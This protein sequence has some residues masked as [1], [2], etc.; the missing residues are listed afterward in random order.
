[1]K[2]EGNN[3]PTER[4]NVNILYLTTKC[5]L[6]CTYCYEDLSNKVKK[7]TSLKDLI[8][9]VDDVL[10][11]EPVD[12]QTLFVLFGGEPTLEWDNIKSIVEYTLS[13]KSNVFFNIETNG[14]KFQDDLFLEN[15][16]D[17][18]HNKP[19]SV[20]ISFDGI[21]NHQRVDHNDNDS[22]FR[23]ISVLNKFKSLDINW[24]IRYTIT[25]SNYTEFA[26]DIAKIIKEFKPKRV[27]TSED[28]ASFSSDDYV[29]IN[30]QKQGLKYLWDTNRINTPI[31]NIFCDT[32]DGCHSS[33][34]DKKYYKDGVLV[35]SIEVKGNQQV[36][37]H[38]ETKKGK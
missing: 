36:F 7:S 17:F 5:N 12:N 38:F 35:D 15:F 1:M 3:K 37:T 19:F 22:T 2:Q 14:I 13:K 33:K 24:R 34:S 21:G 31:C 16:L 8:K 27:I 29:V 9:Q 30:R 25:Q 28:S 32:C 11:N 10:S 23:L 6:N 18:I 20:D 26:Y 4:G